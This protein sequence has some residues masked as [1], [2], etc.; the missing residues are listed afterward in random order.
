MF[1]VFGK[2]LVRNFDVIVELGLS[3]ILDDDVAS[4]NEQILGDDIL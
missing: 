3:S 2:N 1:L 4:S